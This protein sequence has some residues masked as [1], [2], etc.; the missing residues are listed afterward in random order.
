MT[1]PVLYVSPQGFIGGA[2]RS[3]L[4]LLSA[5]DRERVAPAV[6]AFEDGPFLERARAAGVPADVVPIPAPLLGATQRYRG[7]SAAQA[8]GLVAAA[9]PAVA[10]LRAA[11]R[12]RRPAIVHTNGIKAHVLGGFAGRLAGVPVVWH[13]R[14]FPHDGATGRFVRG[15][16]RT[17]PSH[18]IVNSGAVAA[19][20]GLARSVTTVHNGVDFHAFSPEVDGRPFRRSLGLA[21]EH[22]VVGLVAHLTPW[23][24]HLLFLDA[25]AVVAAAE[26]RT[27]FVL[28]GA[29]VYGTEGHGGYADEVR[30]KIDQLGLSDRVVLAGFR[31]DMPAVMRGLDVLVHTSS[32]PE[33]FGRTLIEA[34][35]SARPVVATAAGGVPEVVSDGETGVLVPPRDAR[36]LADAIRRLAEDAPLRDKL[37]RA[38]RER[39]V[40]RFG[41]DR[42]AAA[43]EAVYRAVVGRGARG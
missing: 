24:G 27:R 4:L 35:A 23:K 16:A 40:T 37:G 13:L 20:L 38:G 9:A 14:D 30:R 11:I 33:P 19:S 34:M 39:A 5:L 29:P 42:H 31:D 22:L 12:S 26:P 43:V 7:Y 21:P 32:E 2:E 18:V 41:A 8:L 6:I 17:L 15:L 36:A 1:L 10:R 25:C 3:L 28:V